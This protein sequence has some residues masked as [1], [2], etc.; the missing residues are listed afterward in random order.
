MQIQS[1]STVHAEA[2][3][4]LIVSPFA[5]SL[6]YL[7]TFRFTHQVHSG[8][9]AS[10]NIQPPFYVLACFLLCIPKVQMLLCSGTFSYAHMQNLQ[11]YQRM[12][13]MLMHHRWIQA[14]ADKWRYTCSLWWVSFQPAHFMPLL[15]ALERLNIHWPGSS[16]CTVPLRKELH[17]YR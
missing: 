12:I 11:M 15:T 2:S 17:W 10:K 6:L 14:H 9:H 8:F 7:G 1:L 4:H 5:C 3:Q 16:A 13:S